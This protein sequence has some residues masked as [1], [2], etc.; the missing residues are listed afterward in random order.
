MHVSPYLFR[1]T[2]VC[3]NGRE[4]TQFPHVHFVFLSIDDSIQ[5]LEELHPPS[6]KLMSR[7]TMRTHSH[8]EGKLSQLILARSSSL[9]VM[10][11]L[12]RNPASEDQ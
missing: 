12:S 11:D 4:C 9:I 3:R 8:G 7:S 1:R 10:S 6:K 5:K 2:S